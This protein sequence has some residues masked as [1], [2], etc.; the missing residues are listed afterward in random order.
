MSSRSIRYIGNRK[1]H[2]SRIQFCKKVDTVADIVVGI[3][4]GMMEDEVLVDPGEDLDNQDHRDQDLGLDVLDPNH[5]LVC[6]DLG[7]LVF[8]DDRDHH[9]LRRD[10]DVQIH[11]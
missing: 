2:T 7:D 11:L 1:I 10:L 5:H 6:L 4:E 3:A 8:Q 9:D